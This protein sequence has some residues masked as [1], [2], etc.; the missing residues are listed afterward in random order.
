[1]PIQLD[2]HDALVLEP[3]EVEAAWSAADA[4]VRSCDLAALSPDELAGAACEVVGTLPA[5]AL[6]SVHAYR[7]GAS[8]D[9]VLLLRGLLAERDFGRT[10]GGSAAPLEGAPVQRAALLLL[11]VMLLLGEPFNFRTLY[12]GRLVQHVVPVPSM[13]FTQTSESSSGS[14]DWHVEDGFSPDRCDYVGLLC[15]RGDELASTQF[16]AARDLDLPD[17]VRRILADARFEMHPDTAHQLV[18]PSPTRTSVLFGPAHATEICY[19]AHYLKPV[20]PE[21]VEDAAAL[22]ALG[23]ELDRRSRR[24]VLRRG[25]LLVLDNRRVVHARTPFAARHDGSD[26]WLLRTMVCASMPRYR[27]RGRRII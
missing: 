23:V 2:A 18:D 16:A 27:R 8:S 20:S 5:R 1:V 13:E 22:R 7:S 15:L 10:P 14:L 12:R 24:H 25:D 9:D 6:R 26:R 19:D 17:E 3:S 21:R 11:G 4:I